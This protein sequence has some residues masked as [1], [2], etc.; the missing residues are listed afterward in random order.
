MQSATSKDVRRPI[1]RKK[2]IRG[3]LRLLRADDWIRTGCFPQKNEQGQDGRPSQSS[4]P[5]ASTPWLR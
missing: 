4:L 2:D 5:G 1:V 3:S